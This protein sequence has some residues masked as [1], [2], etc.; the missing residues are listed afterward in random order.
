MNWLF[1]D[2]SFAEAFDRRFDHA[3]PFSEGY[4]P[5]RCKGKWGY[6]DE[7]GNQRIDF[8]YDS[9]GHF[10]NGRSLVKINDGYHCIDKD[11]NIIFSMQDMKYTSSLEY[12]NGIALAKGK[13]NL[14]GY[15]DIYGNAVIDFKYYWASP[16]TDGIAIIRD[17][18]DYYVI[19]DSGTAILGPAKGAVE[20]S[21]KYGAIYLHGHWL[22][23]NLAAS[24]KVR[25]H[26]LI[27]VS[28]SSSNGIY[29]AFYANT[30][31]R[32]YG[33]V[34]AESAEWVDTPSFQWCSSYT[35][36]FAIVQEGDKYGVVDE[37][38]VMIIKPRYEQMPI[39]SG[40][41]A[42]LKDDVSRFYDLTKRCFVGDVYKHAFTFT[43]GYAAVCMK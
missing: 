32:V 31:R 19:S 30:S 12:H 29:S 7:S 5:V 43:Y 10:R 15:V 41:I 3:L 8:K 13:N 14:W 16:F 26:H 33:F 28:S 42:V 17:E 25:L 2:V 9:Y 27:G 24:S 6:I 18:D 21:G 37:K 4:A 22:L 36:G 35:D 20:F 1:L 23:V 38:M 11:D 39:Y 34:S 40:S